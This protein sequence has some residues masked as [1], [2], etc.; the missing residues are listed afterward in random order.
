MNKEQFWKQF[1]LGAHL[2]REPMPPM[3]ELIHDMNI[4][5]SKGFNLVKLQEHWMYDEPTEGTYC[6]DK[7]HELITHAAKLEMGVYLGLTCEHAPNWLW[8]KHPNC[9]MEHKNGTKVMFQAQSTLPGDGKPG[10]CYDDPG[11]MAD[12]LR[13][14]KKVVSELGQHQNIVLWNTWQEIGYWAEWNSGDTVCYCPQTMAFYRRW[15]QSVYVDIDALNQ[16]WRT[17]YMSFESVEADRGLANYAIPQQIFFRY[18]VENVQMANVLQQRYKAIKEAD[19]FDRPVFAHKGYAEV[20]SGV[21][22]VYARTQDFLGTSCYPAWRKA[23]RFDDFM[24]EKRLPRHE[25]LLAEMWDEL[26]Y[27][28]DYIRSASKNGAP[29]WA[30]E[31][32]GGPINTDFS[33]GRVP[34]A[35]DMRRWMLTTMG[36]GATAISFWVTRAEIMGPESN[37]FSLLDSE[38]DSTV[39]FEEAARIGNVLKA[40]PDIFA[41]NNKPQAEVALLVDENNFQ[42][43]KSMSFNNAVQEYYL[44]NLRGWY[45]TLWGMGIACDFALGSYLDEAKVS[46]YKAIIVP[47]AI[48][49]SDTVAM[50]LVEYAKAGG[51]VI[52]EGSCGRLNE[53]GYATRGEIN[54]HI[55]QALDVKVLEHTLVREP[56]DECRWTQPE[57][58]W[59]EYADAGF[60]A[61]TGKMKGFSARANVFVE[62]YQAPPQ[63]TCFTWNENPAGICKDVGKGQMWLV[64]TLLGV[65]GTAYVN[66]DTSNAVK[67]ML[68]KI[69]G[70]GHDGQLLIQK[71]KG[72]NRQAWIITNPCKEAVTEKIIIPQG[73]RVADPLGGNVVQESG[74][75]T[76]T[77]G[78][79]DVRLLVLEQL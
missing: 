17:R 20:G 38:G 35:D 76:I 5:K 69:V 13:F 62:T 36:A 31:Y 63:D 4:L 43:V 25:A 50:A 12:Q 58:T 21:D 39:R 72:T 52:M 9:R 42:V 8:Q 73:V 6:F 49:M 60:I 74:A 53:C 30:A 65:S 79:L 3:S 66:D 26:S 68:A 37:G 56:N 54:P 61:G 27:K 64:G 48:A 7:Y 22:W 75:I 41:L 44:Y 23:H 11:A 34:K 14:I 1:P 70:P 67:Q 78:P 28:M 10:P 33:K 2:C 15:L 46:R 47:F 16:H 32:Q 51:K 18:F 71:R 29:V 57:R 59:G 77:V 40:Y 24:Q 45:K 19:P 55:R